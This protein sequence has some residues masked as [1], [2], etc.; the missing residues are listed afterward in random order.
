M[1]SADRKL[2]A[3][4]ELILMSTRQR[5]QKGIVAFEDCTP[6]LY[7]KLK[8]EGSKHFPDIKQV[9]I[10]EAQDYYPLQYEVFNLL[11]KN[12]KYT[13]L[14]DINQTVEKEN[15]SFLFDEIPARLGNRRAVRM[16]LNKAYR[17]SYE[18]NMFTQ[19]LLRGTQEY[20]SFERHE[21]KPSI[22]RS[23]TRHLM[24]QAIIE[25]I[26]ALRKEGYD[27]IAIICKSKKNAKQIYSEL[28][29]SLEL[30]LFK[31]EDGNIRQGVIVIP[32]YL[33][34]GL[35]FDAVIVINADNINYATEFDR[36]LLYIACTRA[37]H[38]LHIHHTAE[39]TPFLCFAP[40]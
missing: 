31:S 38:R 7:L 36:R 19:A 40:T 12:A 17:S 18:I 15:Q 9:V 28:K 30:Q 32:S 23:T 20:L 1:I 13:V 37:L 22:T 21:Q 2:P 3:D 11:F 6:L 14:G 34:K 24:I 33:A 4:M 8:I 35:E 5:L 29:G 39:I 10:D 26:Q 16:I 25:D 27:T